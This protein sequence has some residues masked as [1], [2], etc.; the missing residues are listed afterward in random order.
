MAICNW[1]VGAML[2]ASLC[3]CASE[4]PPHA[5]P[6]DEGD[7]AH[8]AQTPGQTAGVNATAGMRGATAAAAGSS[9]A[10]GAR[11]SAA[12]SAGM[13]AATSGG[14]S[15]PMAAGSS[16]GAAV[17][18]AAGGA[19]TSPSV[20]GAAAA[21]VT[22]PGGAL[23]GV[24]PAGFTPKPGMNTDFPAGA[25]GRSFNASVP[26]A[27]D[28]PAPVFVSV[29]GTVQE[30]TAFA[31]QAGLSSLSQS[32]WIVLIP[33]R[34]CAQEGRTCN[35]MGMDGR[36]WEPWYDGTAPRGD[37]AGPDV[38]F[39]DAMVRCAASAWPVAADKIYLGGISAGGSFTNRNLTF[40]SKLFAGGVAASGNWTYGVPPASP[41]P[42]D[43]SI[44]I[45]VWGG[46]DDMWPG[47]PPYSE[48]TKAAAEY[49]AAQPNVVTL[50]CSGMHGHM[51]PAAATP[52]MME[53]LLSHPKG[54]DP[55]KFVL[56]PPPS[57]L[58][59]VVG[60]YTDH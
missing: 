46:P 14:P 60:A 25:G 1:L 23:M 5:G 4:D 40:N 47:S 18:P 26:A 29:T 15:Q 22:A 8:A 3:A 34:S 9:A 24:C 6:H 39:I 21:P 13:S 51:W 27:S 20:A 43:S 50:A 19:A 38:A 16:A 57:G 33:F 52:W 31:M 17:P 36:V 49:Y 32:G 58:S 11:A 30:E 45:V 55:A 44:V 7:A 35:A 48:E 59:C 56:K 10:S 2:A 42:M 28:G 53:T 12:G 54:S 41:M 37:D